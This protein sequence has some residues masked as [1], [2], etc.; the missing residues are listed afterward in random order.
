MQAV[1]HCFSGFVRVRAWS[2]KGYRRPSARCPYRMFPL[3]PPR[4]RPC[5]VNAGEVRLFEKELNFVPE[6]EHA[7]LVEVRL[8]HEIRYLGAA[9]SID[10][11]NVVQQLAK[12]EHGVVAQVMPVTSCAK[13]AADSSNNALFCSTVWKV[14]LSEKLI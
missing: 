2:P 9:P 11:H 5:G 13:H 7:N 3:S 6:L 14:C 10:Y 8:G 1:Q 4:V 12:V